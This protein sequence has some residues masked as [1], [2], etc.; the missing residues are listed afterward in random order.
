M[1]QL[2]VFV[3]ISSVIVGEVIRR[4][5]MKFHLYADDS[6]V[7][8][9]FDSDSSVIVPRIEACLHD[10]ATWMSLNKL[11]LNGDKTELLVIGSQHHPTEPSKCHGFSP[12][13]RPYTI[14]WTRGTK[15]LGT[16]LSLMSTFWPTFLSR[17]LS[18]FVSSFLLVRKVVIVIAIVMS[19]L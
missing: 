10:I 11:K 3:V 15:T 4:H 19:V 7:Y 14:S 1:V 8:F 18:T 17:F 9:S 13:F 5:N 6:Q 16:R 2:L 12:L